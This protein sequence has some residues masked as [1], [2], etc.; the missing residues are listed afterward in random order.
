LPNILEIIQ[1]SILEQIPGVGERTSEITL[2]VLLLPEGC[3]L[4]LYDCKGIDNFLFVHV[5]HVGTN[6]KYHFTI[7]KEVLKVFRAFRELFGVG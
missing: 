7:D 1:E 4:A 3:V 5:I 6:S 2:R